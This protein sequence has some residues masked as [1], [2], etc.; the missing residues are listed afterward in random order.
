MRDI[1]HRDRISRM[2]VLNHKDGMEWENREEGADGLS[3]VP[4]GSWSAR[5]ASNIAMMFSGETLAMMLWTCWKTNPPPGA[6]VFT[7]SLT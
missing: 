7:C 4:G 2:C 5:T 1:Y 3:Q 6:R